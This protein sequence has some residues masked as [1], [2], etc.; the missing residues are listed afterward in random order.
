VSRKLM[1][2]CSLIVIIVTTLAPLAAV[3][4]DNNIQGRVN[5]TSVPHTITWTIEAAFLAEISR[6]QDDGYLIDGQYLNSKEIT[7]YISREFQV[8]IPEAGELRYKIDGNIGAEP[9]IHIPITTFNKAG[10]AQ[11]TVYQHSQGSLQ[12]V[13]LPGFLSFTVTFSPEDGRLPVGYT[14]PQA[15]QAG[16]G[17]M[18]ESVRQSLQLP[19][20]QEQFEQSYADYIESRDQ[21]VDIFNANLQS[22][23]IKRITQH[24]GIMGSNLAEKTVSWIGV[25]FSG[26]DTQQI[27]STM[28]KLAARLDD[29]IDVPY[30]TSDIEILLNWGALLIDKTGPMHA[31]TAAT[32]NT[33]EA[34]SR[35]MTYYAYNTQTG[36]ETDFNFEKNRLL[37]QALL[38]D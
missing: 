23:Q 18:L 11:I 24:A 29:P 28:D 20:T 26:A 3:P 12:A 22:R 19:A 8:P 2:I 9:E 5:R 30:L 27:S 4:G 17:K 13:W 25:K 35:L 33:A 32:K 1:L 6:T 36:A 16:T 38:D 10:T 15:P 21:W 37:I 14:L 7:D 31:V 34:L